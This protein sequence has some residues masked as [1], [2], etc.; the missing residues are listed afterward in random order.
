M[1]TMID[2]IEQFLLIIDSLFEPTVVAR[3]RCDDKS[4]SVSLIDGL[5]RSRN[6]APKCALSCV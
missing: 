5:G 3:Q 6:L 4:F 2:G 1:D